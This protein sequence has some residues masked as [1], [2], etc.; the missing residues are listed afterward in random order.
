MSNVV[1][2]KHSSGAW[3]SLV[4]AQSWAL[5]PSLGTQALC[6]SSTHNSEMQLL[7][8]SR[9]QSF[10]MAGPKAGFRNHSGKHMVNVFVQIFVNLKIFQHH[11]RNVCQSSSLMPF[12]M[13]RLP[14]P[15]SPQALALVNMGF[16]NAQSEECGIFST[17]I[18]TSFY[19][20]R[21]I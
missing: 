4:R 7:C 15:C 11:S 16:Q 14:P 21:E 6:T 17:I 19:Q 8:A 5:T 9:N 18:S 1:C 3:V 10:L 2:R 20:L 13:W 12:S